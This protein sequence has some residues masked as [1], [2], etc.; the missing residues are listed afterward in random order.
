M[1]LSELLKDGI[2]VLKEKNI[3]KVTK[4]VRGFFHFKKKPL[5]INQ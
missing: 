1:K 2:Y 4:K 3:M 5:K